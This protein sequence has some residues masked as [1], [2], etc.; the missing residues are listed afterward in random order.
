MT[1]LP[2]PLLAGAY[3]LLVNLA[4][5]AAFAF[6]KR[7]AELRLRRIPESTL[8]LLCALGGSPGGLV[9]QRLKRHK[10]RKRSFQIEFWMIV[11]L[12]AGALGA[13]TWLL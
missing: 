12:Q 13:A 8:L 7:R 10:T 3:L 5:Y 2:L 4:A 11:V 6:D 9:A 1:T